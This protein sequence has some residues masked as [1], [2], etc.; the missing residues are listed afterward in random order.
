MQ[1]SNHQFN[2]HLSWDVVSFVFD[3]FF[4]FILLLTLITLYVIL[5]HSSMPTTT[6]WCRCRCRWSQHCSNT[7]KLKLCQSWWRQCITS[8]KHHCIGRKDA[9]HAHPEWLGSVS[10]PSWLEGAHQWIWIQV[11]LEQKN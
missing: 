1:I 3:M 8:Q 10:N 11:L 6:L 7:N 4:Y 9:G 5:I 2:I